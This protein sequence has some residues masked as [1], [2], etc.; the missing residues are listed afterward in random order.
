[1]NSLKSNIYMTFNIS[2][3]IIKISTKTVADRAEQIPS[4]CTIQLNSTRKKVT[5]DYTAVPITLRNCSSSLIAIK[6]QMSYTKQHREREERL[7]EWVEFCVLYYINTR[8]VLLLMCI[9]IIFFTFLRVQ[10]PKNQIKQKNSN[11]Y[12]KPLALHAEG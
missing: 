2:Y 12:Y 7:D 1:M 4:T 6:K 11:D 10:R 9:N 3:D 8:W 5:C